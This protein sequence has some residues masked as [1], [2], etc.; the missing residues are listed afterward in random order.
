MKVTLARHGGF[1]AGIRR[2]PRTVDSVALPE[3]AAQELTRLVSAA[4]NAPGTADD[5][6]GRARDAMSYTITVEESGQSTVLRQ[7]DTT[8][9]PTFAALLEWLERHPG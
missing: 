8:M 2:P 6:P 7:S 9:S 5:G 4:K 1:A 3:T